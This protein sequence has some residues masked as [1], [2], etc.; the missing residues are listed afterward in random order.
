MSIK[1]NKSIKLKILLVIVSFFTLLIVSTHARFV[2]YTNLQNEQ[3]EILN[4]LMIEE[5][6]TTEAYNL[7]NKFYAAAKDKNLIHDFYIESEKIIN[8]LDNIE[9]GIKDPNSYIKFRGI[10]N[11]INNIILESNKTLNSNSILGISSKYWELLKYA[12]FVRD[13]TA[14]LILS[15][16]NYFNKISAETEKKINE[17]IFYGNIRNILT[18]IVTII[19]T[20]IVISNFTKPI[21]E[22][23]EASKRIS[24]GKYE[25]INPSI[26]NRNDEIG[27]LAESLDQ[28]VM[29]LKEKISEIEYLNKNLEKKV[30]LR[31]KD[32]ENANKKILN[33]LNL[34]TQF[35]N[36]VAHDLR[37]PLTP[38]KALLPIITNDARCGKLKDK[39]RIID[40]NV[41]YLSTL[42]SDTL[43]LSRLDTGK[44]EFHFENISMKKILDDSL[45]AIE[46]ITKQ[47]KVK[48]KNTIKTDSLIVYADKFR[49]TEVIA[50]IIGNSVK[51]MPKKKEV[52][53]SAKKKG[54][55]TQI[56][57]KDSGIGID[58]KYISKIFEEFFKI[59]DSRH[60]AAASSG[61]GL[62]I[63][64]KIIKAHGGKIWAESKGANKGTSLI[65][66]LPNQKK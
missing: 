51:Y 45:K 4:N 59:D 5:S 12:D 30:K 41:E 37:T 46:V 54:K 15:E 14:E 47:N 13:N 25:H 49:I 24:D 6:L 32:L 40:N 35:I 27:I 48:I 58:K 44:S 10:R 20:F 7:V 56:T 3:R 22:L 26:K 60:D 52:E 16:L 28:M 9:A 61:L 36:Q 31:T 64:N 19:A 38:I 42:V 17:S 18:Y 8:T 43:N 62:A 33:L 39:L 23:S 57:I 11:S 55:F 65:F 63:C 50:N 66:T 53:I 29:A 34:K 2:S 1:K 21:I